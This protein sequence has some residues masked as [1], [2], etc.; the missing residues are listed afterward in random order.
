MKHICFFNTIQ[1]WGG[2]EKIYFEYA[3]GLKELGYRVTVVCNEGSVLAKKVKEIE[4]Q[5]F[6]ISASNRSFLHPLKLLKMKNFFQKEAVD[7]VM[8]SA[9]QDL[10]LGGL[11]AHLAGVPQIVYRRGLASPIKNRPLNRF[12]LGKV[13]TLLI[14]NSAETK[15]T[16]RLHLK[17]SIP[18]GKI[19]IIYNGLKIDDFDKHQFQTIEQ[20]AHNR[21]GIILGNAGRLTEQKG[22]L[23]LIKVAS[24]LKKR[25]LDFTLFIA[26][27]GP[28][29]SKLQAN[30]DENQLEKHVILLD[31]VEDIASFIQSIDIFLL[32]S[33]WEGFGFV[34]AE[35]M[36][37]AKPI[38]AFD[39]TSNPELIIDGQTGYLVPAD[40]LEQFANRV[41]LL[42]QDE[43]KR[44]EF[45]LAGRKRVEVHFDFHQQLKKLDQLLFSDKFPSA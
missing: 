6:F 19:K 23:L 14:A 16:I 37:Y 22:H 11:A 10:K 9:S 35:A 20:I 29:K 1:F 36:V 45:G 3:V 17:D 5:T 39:I 15:R 38:V 32:S 13:T 26:G 24:I 41:E 28:L 12:L 2:G 25:N 42:I 43:K 44:S 33:L 8:F 27:S 18:E 40:N 4:I 21:N 7:V 31:F 34:L 30:I